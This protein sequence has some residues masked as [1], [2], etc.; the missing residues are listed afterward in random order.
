MDRTS[1]NPGMRVGKLD[2]EEIPTGFSDSRNSPVLNIPDVTSSVQVTSI[3][4]RP[5]PSSASDSTRTSLPLIPRD[6]FVSNYLVNESAMP[7][8]EPSLESLPMDRTT[9]N[10]GMRVGQLDGEEIPT[11]FSDSRNSPAPVPTTLIVCDP[12]QINRLSEGG[13]QALTPPRP[14]SSE[15]V[16]A[17]PDISMT[18]SSNLDIGR[19]PAEMPVVEKSDMIVELGTSGKGDLKRKMNASGSDREGDTTDHHDAHVASDAGGFKRKRIT[20]VED[21]DSDIIYVGSWRPPAGKTRKKEKLHIK[22]ENP[23]SDSN[24]SA[25]PFIDTIFSSFKFLPTSL[26]LPLVQL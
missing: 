9:A 8:I 22:L 11:G 12:F 19:N 15:T 7:K 14:T 16:N 2:G 5:G 10:P 25:K 4:G 23:V 20:T 1:A 24:V 26:Y 13:H 18:S 3:A 6:E 21:S 17:A